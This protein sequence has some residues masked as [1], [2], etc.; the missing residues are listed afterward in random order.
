MYVSASIDVGDQTVRAVPVDEYF[1]MNKTIYKISE[2]DCPSEENIVRMKLEGFENI[3]SLQFDIPN[4]KLEVIHEGKAEPITAAI[5][6]LNFNST[7][8]ATEEIDDEEEL[9]LADTTGTERKL[10]WQVL[11]INFFFFALEIIT[12]IISGSMGLVADSLDMLADAVVYGLALFVVG[13]AASHKRRIAHIS[14]YFQLILAVFGF[15]EVVRRFLGYGEPPEF[16]TMIGISFFAKSVMQFHF[17]Y[18]KDQKA[19]KPTCRQAQYLL[20]MM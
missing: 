10:L 17:I 9:L 15:A 14:G 8:L 3:K 11:A 13:K 7:L 1:V 20:Q 4:R 19:K 5:G 2:M 6:S 12:G 16:K 18:C